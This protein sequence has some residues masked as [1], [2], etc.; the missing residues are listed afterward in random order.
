VRN[1]VKAFNARGLGCLQR[2]S[3]RPKTVHSVFGKFQLACLKALLHQSPRL[4][5]KAQSHW[6]LKLVAEV[7]YSQGITPWQVS[8][9]TIR[10]AVR[11]LGCSW[12]RAKRWITSPDPAYRRKKHARD[13]LIRLAQQHTDWVLGYVDQT[14][15]SRLARSLGYTWCAAESTGLRLKELTLPKEDP[16]PK[17]LA[18]YGIWMPAL[19]ELWLRFVYGRPVS[20]ITIAFLAWTL[21]RLA[22]RGKTALLLIW[23]NAT[24]HKSHAVTNW[25]KA[26]NQ[27]VKETGKGVRIVVCHLPV[28]SPWLNPIEPKWL[29]GKRAVAESD[30]LLSAEE[31]QLRVCAYYGCD[32]LTPLTQPK[33]KKVA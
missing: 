3:S 16:D 9:E 1:V 10:K 25:I 6:T 8:V 17:A 30:R 15:W 11:C 2:Q 29:H 33:S 20:A 18:C 19:E 12:K 13:R 24:W 4:Y 28:K 14:W 27:A 7:C 23:D 26:H 22:A 5:G 21:K 31:I 32:L